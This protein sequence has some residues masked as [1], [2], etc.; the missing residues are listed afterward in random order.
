MISSSRGTSHLFTISPSGGKVNIP[1]SD[2][3]FTTKNSGSGVVTKPSVYGPPNS[4]LQMLNQQKL[5][6]SG[7]PVA[8]SAVSRIRSGNNGWRSSVTGAAAAATGRMGSFCGAITSAFHNCKNNDLYGDSSYLKAKYHLLVF[9]PSGCVIQY[10]LRM[11]SGLDCVTGVSGLSHTYDLAPECDARLVV[12]PI[13][14]WN[15]C[16]KQN[17]RERENNIDIYGENGNSDS[18]KIFPEEMRNGNIDFPKVKGTVTKVKISPEERHHM[19]ISEAELQ[20]HL[21]WVPFWARS[22]VLFMICK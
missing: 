4:G 9:S 14:K 12:E 2:A 10:A 20:M 5:C 7:P 6:E 18:S 13:Q 8:L 19:H 16:Q 21:P 1:Y 11:S 22:E 17:Q 3:C 15:I